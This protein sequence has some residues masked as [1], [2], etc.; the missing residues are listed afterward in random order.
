MF[1][2]FLLN[3]VAYISRCF[4]H[5]KLKMNHSKSKYNF[6]SLLR[7]PEVP[8]EHLGRRS[9]EA[10]FEVDF[11]QYYNHRFGI[12]FRCLRLPGIISSESEVGGGTTGELFPTV[13]LVYWKSI[14]YLIDIGQCSL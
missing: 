4:E 13:S 5:N 8:E 2:H 12:D 11:L 10:E 1:M 6:N 7:M 3:F 14:T 9:G